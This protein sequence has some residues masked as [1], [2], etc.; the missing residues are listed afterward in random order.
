[1]A[2]WELL[3]IAISQL[4]SNKARTLLTTLG[5][6]I[7]V[8]SVVGVVSIGE[9]LRRTVM[10]ELDRLGGN[11]MIMVEPPREWIRVG[12][13]WKRRGWVDSLTNDDVERIRSESTYT[14]AV[15]PILG[16]EVRISHGDVD[17]R[18]ELQGTDSAY[19]ATMGWNLE[20]GRFLLP[21]DIR[22]RERVCVI[23]FHHGQ[24]SVQAGCRTP[25]PIGSDQRRTLPGHR[26]HAGQ[27][28]VRRRLGT[29]G[30]NPL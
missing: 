15:L 7:G 13:E 14:A 6:L 23:G 1:M 10:G 21:G 19:A 11:R 30:D 12:F 18:G 22:D 3:V 26:G 28:P 27:A 17:T 4:W 24:G 25:G 20:L 29:Q 16:G 9:G 2:F 5:I 8:G